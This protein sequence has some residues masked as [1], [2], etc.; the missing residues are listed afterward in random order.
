[1]RGKSLH[2]PSLCVKLQNVTN[3][4]ESVINFFFLIFPA[5]VMTFCLILPFN[6]GFAKR[7]GADGNTTRK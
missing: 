7:C 5:I 2:L 6:P 3:T 1:M 4:R